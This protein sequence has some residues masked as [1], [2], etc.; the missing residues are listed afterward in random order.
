MFLIGRDPLRNLPEKSPLAKQKPRY[1]SNG[2]AEDLTVFSEEAGDQ[3]YRQLNRQDK[4]HQSEEISTITSKTRATSL[5]D[6]GK[7][8]ASLRPGLKMRSVSAGVALDNVLNEREQLKKTKPSDE[9]SK[10]HQA[11]SDEILSAQSESSVMD[12][13]YS[14]VEE[15]CLNLEKTS[16]PQFGARNS[17][18]RGSPN[19]KKLVVLRSFS[20]QESGEVSLEE[21]EEVDV[22]QKE[23]SGW[24]YVKNDFCEGW[25]PSAFLAPGRSRSISP[26]ILDQQ[27]ISDNQDE[28]WQIKEHV[29]SVPKQK[30]DDLKRLIPPGKEKVGSLFIT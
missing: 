24:W 19:R 11:G 16:S 7:K 27:Q 21:G 1:S 29:D 3:P 28:H 26:E 5:D 13:A 12:S 9:S 30:R 14:E 20:A 6:L 4:R 22:L 18:G 2:I 23:A 15:P 17:Y 25:A 10:Q 8:A